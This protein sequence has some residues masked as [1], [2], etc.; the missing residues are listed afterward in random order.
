MAG[1][2]D[3]RSLRR[4]LRG[5]PCMGDLSDT[6]PERIMAAYPAL[7]DLTL[8]RVTALL[9][10]LGNPQ[11][12][13]PPVVHVAGTNG[14]GSV[15]AMV[16]AGL[17]AAGLRA[18]VYTSPHLVE[19]RERFRLCGELMAAAEVS[20]LIEEC[21]AFGRE[22]SHF[23]IAT[24]AA[25][26]AFSRRA[27]DYCLLETGLGGRLDA[28]NVVRRPAATAITPV[29]HDHHQHLGGTL[30]LIAGE[31]AGILKPGVPCA[32]GRQ[33]AEAMAVIE[34]R[35]ERV[36]APLLSCGR[37]WDVYEERGRLV[38]QDGRGLLD[39]P[40][41]NLLG[42][43]QVQNA[44]IAL[45]VLRVL[46]MG[47]DAFEGAV[48]RAEWPARMQRLRGGPLR[49]LAPGAEI[50]LDGGHNPAAGLAVAESLDRLGPRPVRLVFGMLRTK[51]L[52]GYLAPLA[53]RVARLYAVR[54]QGEPES[55]SER[56]VAEGARGLGIDAVES[57][58]V[59]DA[60]AAAARDEPSA[61]ILISGSLYLAGA[62]LRESP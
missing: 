10:D 19:F 20:A 38:F 18:H 40:L 8:D 34:A 44:G 30:G 31:K 11:D 6:S 24:C 51:D 39:L 23:E 28:T 35:A 1:V 26:L 3:G 62:V 45:A 54:I 2:D 14:K 16:R 43:H 41:P 46:G 57:F 21:A 12:R 56:E 53:S 58:S 37:D 55:F 42:A 17:E 60:V 15:I 22:V 29:S 36:G 32:V 59:R 25:L 4:V 27:A 48:S 5:M 9:G 7:I 13:L 49:R 33:E 52:A 47:E 50:F 61:R